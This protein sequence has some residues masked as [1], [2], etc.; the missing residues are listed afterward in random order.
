MHRL[1]L[2]FGKLREK[3]L[4]PLGLGL[5]GVNHVDVDVVAIAERR[6]ALGEIREGRI[7][8]TADQKIRA[9]RACGAADNIND[10]AVRFLQQRPE[11]LR[12]P[13]C[14]VK[15]QRKAVGPG[16]VRLFKKL[17]ALGGA[18]IVDQ[19]VAALEAIIDLGEDLLAALK[20]AQVAGDRHRRRG[21]RAGN[22]LRRF[23]EVRRIR[24]RQ[25]GLR[26][27]AREGDRN[28]PADTA[29]AATDDDHFSFEFLRHRRPLVDIETTLYAANARIASGRQGA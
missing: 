15:F 10:V 1:A 23:G 19:Y 18:G 27:L 3:L 6:E 24:R 22:R 14:A 12:E 2:R 29:A 13:H 28:R 21:T 26:A 20:R 4:D 17:A 11:R 8:R 5:A 25:H 9:R 16:V 7:D